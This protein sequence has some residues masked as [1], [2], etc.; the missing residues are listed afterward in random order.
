MWESLSPRIAY[1][2]LQ[3]VFDVAL[4]LRTTISIFFGTPLEVVPF[5]NTT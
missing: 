5:S 2:L 1:K 3:A 4:D